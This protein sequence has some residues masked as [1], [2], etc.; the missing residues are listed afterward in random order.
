MNLPTTYFDSL[1]DDFGIWQH[2]DGVRPLPEHGYALDDAARGFIISLAL[3]KH[4]QARTLLRYLTLSQK[5]GRFYGFFNA[6]RQPIQFP[7]SED[8][9]GQVVW[10]MGYAIANNFAVGEARAIIQNVMPAVQT[11]T[12]LRGPVYALLG[13]LYGDAA[14]ASELYTKLI[15][16][17]DNLDS[18]WPWPEKTLTYANGLIPYVLLRYAHLHDD[19][20]AAE[21]GRN[22]LT[23]LEKVCTTGRMRGPVGNHG[24]F[25]RGD[26][27][28]AENGQ[29]PIDVTCMIGAWIAA[30]EFSQDL[31]DL[32]QAHAWMKWY[33]GDNIAHEPMFDPL[34]GKGFDGI[35]IGNPDHHTASGRNTDSGAESNI[36]YL[37]ARYMLTTR[38]TL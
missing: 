4:E 33:E 10:A 9:T 7:A 15:R 23:F 6:D 26:P 12:T 24:W 31:G 3:G 35:D 2:A 38:T 19:Q 20:R 27:L 30:Y 16:Q 1:F 14:L 11:F 29:Q 28:P 25:T 18:D 32:Q 22:I 8:A 13:A 5:D 21:T 36:C 34:S 37:M 17:F